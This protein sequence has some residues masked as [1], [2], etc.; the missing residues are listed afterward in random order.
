MR[1][2]YVLQSEKK[3][4]H[5]PW[6]GGGVGIFQQSQGSAKNPSWSLIA[7]QN[8]E[9]AIYLHSHLQV[10]CQAKTE[11]NS[12]LNVTFQIKKRGGRNISSEDTYTPIRGRIQNPRV[13]H[14]GDRM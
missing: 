8:V 5:Q 9:I 11:R 12:G 7:V 1:N 10:D 2:S 14:K 3:R 13:L 6:G 4:Q